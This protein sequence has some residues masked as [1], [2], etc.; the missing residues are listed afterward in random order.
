M[1][2]FGGALVRP[3]GTAVRLA[4]EVGVLS[5]KMGRRTAQTGT[6]ETMNPGC[7]VSTWWSFSCSG[8]LGGNASRI[9]VETAEA[10]NATEVEEEVEEGLVEDNWTNGSN[11]SGPSTAWR[12][13][14]DGWGCGPSWGSWSGRQVMKKDPL[15]EVGVGVYV[16]VSL[17][18]LKRWM[19]E[20]QLLRPAS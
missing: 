14:G 16:C 18:L 1:R 4:C 6:A 19:L 5:S 17:Q 2:G 13:P 10:P 20:P 3:H 12:T 11:V 15:W 8:R 7:F 9:H